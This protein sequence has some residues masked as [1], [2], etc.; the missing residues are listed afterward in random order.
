[1]DIVKSK[2]L[3]KIIAIRIQIIQHFAFKLKKDIILHKME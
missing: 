1:M 3:H 2:H